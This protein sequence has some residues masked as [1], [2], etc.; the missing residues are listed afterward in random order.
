MPLKFAIL[1][2]H[3]LSIKNDLLNRITKIFVFLKGFMYFV[4]TNAGLKIIIFCTK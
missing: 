3:F 4:R 2:K 1:Y